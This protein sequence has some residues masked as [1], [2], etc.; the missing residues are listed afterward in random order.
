M[1]R[2]LFTF[3]C[4]GTLIDWLGGIRSKFRELYPEFPEEVERFVSYWSEKDF[5]LV[6]GCYKPYKEILRKGFRYAIERLRLPYDDEILEKL[7]YSIKEWKPFQDTRENL[8]L[9][10]EIGEIGIISNTDREFISASINNMKVEFDYVIVAEDLKIYKPH[11]EVFR[12]AKNILQIGVNDIWIHISSYIIYDIIP[13]RK[14]GVYT[15]LLDRYKFM[16]MEETCLADEVYFNF[17]ELT[18]NIR[19][20]FRETK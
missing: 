11:P 17:G 20:R 5:L 1:R 12:S 9:L 14:A 10:K 8:L 15:I 3:D 7:T 13:A 6:G 16:E 4:Y 19:R 2:T 18:E